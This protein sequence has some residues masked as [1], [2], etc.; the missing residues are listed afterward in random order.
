LRHHPLRGP[1]LESWVAS[2]VYKHHSH[3]GNNPKLFQ[4]REARGAEID[5]MLQSASNLIACKAKPGATLQPDFMRHL[6]AFGQRVS[7]L[8]PQPALNLRLVYGADRRQQ[9]DGVD[10]LG[11]RQIHA[12][13]WVESATT[14]K[15][16]SVKY[17]VVNVERANR[18]CP[19]QVQSTSMLSC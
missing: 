6:R 11:W 17:R 13:D 15:R 8:S 16:S 5:I 1:I 3:R 9:R 12:V 10:R 19:P 14:R 4:Y 7:T 18:F 2:E